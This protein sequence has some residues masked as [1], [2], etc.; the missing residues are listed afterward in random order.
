MSG[1]IKHFLSMLMI[2]CCVIGGAILLKVAVIAITGSGC[3]S[4]KVLGTDVFV[5]EDCKDSAGENQ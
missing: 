2:V 3:A 4:V 1:F 5:G